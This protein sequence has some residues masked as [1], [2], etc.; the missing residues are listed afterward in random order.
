MPGNR[1][2]N[3]GMP[4]LLAQGDRLLVLTLGDSISVET[5]RQC[6]RIAHA[7][8][9][10]AF[11]EVTDVVPTFT[12]VAIHTRPVP[13]SARHGSLRDRIHA[14]IQT[15]AADT[16]ADTARTIDIPV[17]YEEPCSPDLH[18]V[19]RHCGVSPAQIIALHSATPAYVFMLGFA[20]G[21]PYIGLHDERLQ[22]G[23]RDTP[24]T[25][26]PAGSVAIAN[27][28]TMIYPHVSPGGWHIIG[29]T[30][31]RLFNPRR[32]PPTLLEPGDNVRFVPVS[33]DTFLQLQ[34]GEP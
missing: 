26:V 20:P 1:Q 34:Q 4:P 29:A 11:P 33:H 23:R 2:N 14:V 27:R 3:T 30:P 10:A 25:A 7:L 9:Q 8:R 22:I 24:R 12:T 13:H 19:A 15:V 32:Q 16:T 6:A 18:H 21:A 5:G 28:Q 31:V 17:C